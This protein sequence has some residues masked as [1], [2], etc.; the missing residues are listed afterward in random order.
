[1]LHFTVRL[2]PRGFDKISLKW[3]LTS[4]HMNDIGCLVSAL[5]RDRMPRGRD[6]QESPWYG[7]RSTT[8]YT[9]LGSPKTS[10]D[11]DTG[12]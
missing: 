5:V 7:V 10:S 6:C 8:M 4:V 3:M 1:M 2:F 12:Q 9:S 11:I